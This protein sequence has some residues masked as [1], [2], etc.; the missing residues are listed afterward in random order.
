MAYILLVYYLGVRVLHGHTSQQAVRKMYAILMG[1]L[2]F[3]MSA[4][5]A[6]TVGT[7]VAGYI[8]HFRKIP[9]TSIV[10]VITT[11][12]DRGF[13]VFIK[14]L[15]YLIS[16]PRFYL[17]VI[18][19][20]FALSISVF[21]YRYSKE[22]AFSFFALLPLSFIYFSMTGLRQT[23]AMSVVLFAYPYIVR[24]KPLHFFL[25]IILASA[26]H[27]S[28]LIFSLAYLASY[29]KWTWKT[30]AVISLSFIATYLGR[31]YIV[32]LLIYID[33]TRGYDITDAG[34]GISTLLMFTGI[35]LFTLVYRNSV[36][37][38]PDYYPM[39]FLLVLGMI[40]QMMTPVL[41][42]MYRIAMYFNI[43]VI[44][45]LPTVICRINDKNMRSNYYMGAVC[46][47][48]VLYFLFTYPGAGAYPYGFYWQR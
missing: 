2:L 35:F 15:S 13:Y 23:L 7:D 32:M 28:A 14:L 24:R 44:V 22:P 37:D 36:V 45:F 21:I 25:L 4:L 18:A 39:Y 48:C 6:D 26:F 27:K 5:R 3:I 40:F 19:A 17:V 47:L 38:D 20:I 43:Y 8:E 16:N 29:I 34:G 33:P 30:I 31:Y 1:S 42:E 10:D 46:C 41:N 9:N 11:G 12:K